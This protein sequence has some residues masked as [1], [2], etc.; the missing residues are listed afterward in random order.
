[1]ESL[2]VKTSKKQ[3][4]VKIAFTSENEIAREISREFKNEAKFFIADTPTR[5]V[6]ERP[7]VVIHTYEIDV[8]ESSLKPNAAWNVNTWFA[9]NMA[10]A[11]NR[12]G[13]QNLYF[14]TFMTYDGKKGYYIEN[15]PPFPLNYY[16]LTKLAGEIGIESMGNF[17]VLRL[18]VLFSLNYKGLLYPFIKSA[19]LGRTLKCNTN[20]F[21]SVINVKTL[22]KIVVNL[23]SKGVRGII[24]VGSNRVSFYEV[25]TYLSDIFGNEVVGFEGVYRDFSLDDWILRR[26]YNIKIKADE[27]IKKIL[28]DKI[29]KSS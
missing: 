23:L 18:G 6:S 16:G 21:L 27:E 11:A 12:I 7:D 24:N 29:S 4:L 20:F 3:N 13:A 19:V 2:L 22:A 26:G 14:S 10:R 9:I 28:L 8:F 1:M 25:C 17:L 5:I 15:N